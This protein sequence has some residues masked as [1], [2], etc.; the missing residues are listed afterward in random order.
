MAPKAMAARPPAWADAL[1]ADASLTRHIRV[2]AVLSRTATGMKVI[3]GTHKRRKAVACTVTS[4]AG[5]ALVAN[6]HKCSV[7]RKELAG[8]WRAPASPD[9][10]WVGSCGGPTAGRGLPLQGE[11]VWFQ[12]VAD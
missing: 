8:H 9:R 11:P 2:A 7:E 5:M 10:H 12:H 4:T 6:E 1:L 3:M